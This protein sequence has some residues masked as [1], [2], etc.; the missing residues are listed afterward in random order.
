MLVALASELGCGGV[1]QRDRQWYWQVSCLKPCAFCANCREVGFALGEEQAVVLVP[2]VEIWAEERRPGAQDIAANAIFAEAG[3]QD[4]AYGCPEAHTILT[5]QF[6][7]AQCA[8]NEEAGGH[9]EHEDAAPRVAA[10][11]APIACRVVPDIECDAF[12]FDFF[13][14][15]P[16]PQFAHIIVDTLKVVRVF[17]NFGGDDRGEMFDAHCRGQLDGVACVLEKRDKGT[18]FAVEWRDV[19]ACIK[20]ALIHRKMLPAVRGLLCDEGLNFG[21]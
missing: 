12:M 16:E 14:C 17:E 7:L 10:G 2:G 3:A 18:N 15:V 20:Q 13:D 11:G 9:R 5:Q 21:P 19:V 4:A 1:F 6:D 8:V